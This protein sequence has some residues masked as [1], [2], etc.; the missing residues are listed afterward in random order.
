MRTK[1]ELNDYRYFPE[2]DLPPLVLSDEFIENIKN[3]IPELP[4]AKEE[5]YIKEFEISSDYART[6]A[7]NPKLA[8][9][10]ESIVNFTVRAKYV[11]NFLLVNISAFLNE[12]G[13][14]IDEIKFTKENFKELLDL[15]D[16][17]IISLNIAKEVLDESLHTG[18]SPSEIVAKK[19][20]T[21][22]TDETSIKEFVIDVLKENDAQVNQYLS[23]KTKV[24]A[25]LIGQV[26]KKSKGKANPEL[27][28]RILYNELKNL[29]K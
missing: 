19:R 15:I 2:P 27:V 9:Y 22:I 14:E 24:M 4:N 5:R 10:F 6:I 29:R 18:N 25:Y 13:K 1:E 26:M 28:N 12:T 7:Y 3:T 20:L 21:Q 16:N 17:K 23:G 8:E 11:A